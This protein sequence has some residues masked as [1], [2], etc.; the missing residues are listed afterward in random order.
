MRRK[1]KSSENTSPAR[2]KSEDRVASVSAPRILLKDITKMP[3]D[4]RS[5][6]YR[7]GD[8]FRNIPNGKVKVHDVLD[9]DDNEPHCNITPCN[10]KHIKKNCKS[11][12]IV[13]I[14]DQCKSDLNN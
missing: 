7:E 12:Q 13:I 2:S 9:F 14:D 6:W 10:T 1:S 11:C 3:S 5:L 4:D 8:M